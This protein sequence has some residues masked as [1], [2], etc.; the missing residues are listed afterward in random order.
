MSSQVR[1]VESFVPSFKLTIA[2]II[3]QDVSSPYNNIHLPLPTL[4][5]PAEPLVTLNGNSLSAGEAT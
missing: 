5:P 4:R 1:Q 3:R 2:P